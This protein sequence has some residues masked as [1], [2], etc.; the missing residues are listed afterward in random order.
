MIRRRAR[1]EEK[2]A[3]KSQGMRRRWPGITKS[4]HAEKMRGA[5]SE[6]RE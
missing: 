4:L 6:E 3:N 2:L 1:L 5:G